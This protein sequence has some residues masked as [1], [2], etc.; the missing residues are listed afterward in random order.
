MPGFNQ[1]FG[2][3]RY[4]ADEYYHRALSAMARRDYDRAIANLNDAIAELPRNPEYIA[5]RGLVHLEEA[6]YD[7]AEADFAAA[8]DI[9]KFEMLANYGLGFIALKRQEYPTAVKYLQAAYYID[10]KR[11]ETLYALGVAFYHSGDVVN[12]TQFLGRANELFEKANDKRKSESAR[13]LRELAKHVAKPARPASPS[14]PTSRQQALP[15][16]DK[17]PPKP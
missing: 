8:L 6:E 17:A 13:W 2:L 14:L 1:R 16:S 9:D 11:P 10:Q 4:A 3:N 12:A 5:A 15:L 7:E